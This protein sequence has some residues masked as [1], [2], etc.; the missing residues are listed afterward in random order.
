MYYPLKY[1]SMDDLLGSIHDTMGI[2][3][4]AGSPGAEA[5]LLP[6][7]GSL[8][9]TPTRLAQIW[10]RGLNPANPE[11]PQVTSS[12][13]EFDFRNQQAGGG[14]TFAPIFEWD[15]E[16]DL[17]SNYATKQDYANALIAAGKAMIG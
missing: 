15:G 6:S 7:R 4:N 8:V 14:F 9:F 17:Q 12:Q 10:C 3:I 16:F 5:Y 11:F 2:G 13:A 1:Q